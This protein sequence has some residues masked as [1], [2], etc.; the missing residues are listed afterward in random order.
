M[1]K[2]LIEYVALE[3]SLKGSHYKI[4]LLLSIRPCNQSFISSSL[5]IKKQNIN[6]CFKE[7]LDFGLIEVD[8]IEGRNKFY[9]VISDVSKINDLPLK[10]QLHF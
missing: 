9:K 1:N 7:L 4:L 8:R 2:K 3:P 5:G 6:K 10:G